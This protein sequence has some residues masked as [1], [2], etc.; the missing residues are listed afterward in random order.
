M[1]RVNQTF[2]GAPLFLHPEENMPLPKINMKQ[3][4]NDNLTELLDFMGLA[5]FYCEDNK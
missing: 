5:F 2:F 3:S 4:R 1:S